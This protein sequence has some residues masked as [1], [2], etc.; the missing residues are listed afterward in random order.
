[1]PADVNSVNEE[2]K[3]EAKKVLEN[4]TGIEKVKYF[5]Y[6]YKVHFLVT[7]GVI[8]LLSYIIFWYATMKDCVF[9]TIVVNGQFAEVFDYQSIMDD[10]SSRV[11]YDPKE[12]ELAIE[13]NYQ[14]DIEAQDQMTRTTIQKV[15]LYVTSQDLDVIICDESFMK[16]TRAQDCAAD[17]SKVLPSDMLDKYADNLLWY[18]FPIE[19]VGEDYYE[20]DY[21]GRNE[22]CSMEI[23]EFA[24]I[25]NSNMFEGKKVYAII[26]ANSLHKDTA[27]DFL[28]Y[29][30]E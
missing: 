19:E 30:D 29:L 5:V 11:E 13:G 20:E 9:R 25:K 12:E 17:L 16:L 4:K 23:T 3:N 10:F 2:I 8:A 14:L 22:A 7:V 1:M 21:A 28:K 24:K 26:I 27:I 18:D 6:Y 15:F